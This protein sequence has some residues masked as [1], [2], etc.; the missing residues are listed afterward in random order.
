MTDDDK[1]GEVIEL[2]RR[3]GYQADLASIA[4]DQL[5]RARQLRNAS[6]EEFADLLT[7]L[8]GW[9]VAADIVRSWETTAVPPGDALV[10][11]SVITQ[12]AGRPTQTHPHSDVVGGLIAERFADL[13]EVYPTRAEFAASLPARELFNDAV[14]I[15]ACGLSLNLICQQYGD[16][17]IREMIAR[18]THLRCLFLDPSGVAMRTRELEEGFP[19]GHLAAL[20]ELNIQGLIRRVRDRLADDAQERLEV[21][22]Y[23]ET[24]RFNITIVDGV[25]CVVQPYLPESRGVDSP[26][27]VIRRQ[28]SGTGL[29]NTFDQIFNMLWERRKSL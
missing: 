12:A 9:P 10:A 15:K 19:T 17:A 6:E 11:A 8:L 3:A 4:R 21:A 13:T 5:R 1:G 18:G 22:T 7:P 25:T 28:P 29:Y 23:N 20:T 16:T 14:D 26:T 2:H 27:F 24:V